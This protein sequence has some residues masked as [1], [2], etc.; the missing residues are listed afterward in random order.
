VTG[1]IIIALAAFAA[2]LLTLVSGFGLGT[3]LTP[4]FAL[5]FPIETAI[6]ATAV[7]HLANNLFK[8]GLLGR[9]ADWAVAFGFGA[10]A[11][12]AAFT[13]AAV[14][15]LVS[16]LPVLARYD[17]FG[18]VRT[19]EPLPL[20]IGLLIATFAF[21]EF[22]PQFARLAVPKRYLAL[23]GLISGF[24]GG[25]SGH[26]G[27]LRSAFLVK[28]GLDKEA[29]IATGVVCAVAVD[30]VRIAVYAAF[31]EAAGFDLLPSDARIEAVTATIA[32]FAGAFVGARLIRKL[33]LRHVQL[34]VAGMMALIGAGLASGLF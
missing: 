14:L 8:L 12:G 10:P 7:V 29:F 20:I 2:S 9:R 4:V 11:A 5:F 33:T 31:A 19:I 15:V 16:D 6:A 22:S 18:A 3:L 32:A 34:I 24:F 23:G 25:L 27:A 1:I 17:A 30:L 21:L 28:A 26:Q 13:G